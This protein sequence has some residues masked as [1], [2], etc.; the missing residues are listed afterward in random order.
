MK[1]TAKKE[2]P[3]AVWSGS[4][5]LFGVVVYCHN[6]SNG[7]RIIEADSLLRLLDAMANAPAPIKD[8]V[9]EFENFARWQ[10]GIKP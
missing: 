8:A 4:F 6:L 9:T 3:T 7:Q 10:K 1:R 5:T 2:I